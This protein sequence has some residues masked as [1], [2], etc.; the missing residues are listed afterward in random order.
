[1]IDISK[2][3]PLNQ[4]GLRLAKGFMKKVFKKYSEEYRK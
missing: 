2:I 1:M 4:V 3:D